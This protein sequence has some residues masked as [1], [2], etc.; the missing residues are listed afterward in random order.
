[1]KK[2]KLFLLLVPCLFLFV[3]C[4]ILNQP[5]IQRG[6]EES[7]SDFTYVYVVPTGDKTGNAGV[8]YSL[9]YGIYASSPDKSVNPGDLIAGYLMKRGY[10]RLFALD[11]QLKES[12][13]IVSYGEVG[14]RPV[15]LAAYTTAVT[16]QMV[17]GK[18]NRM[19]C[20]VTAE[21]IGDTEADDIRQ[22]ISRALEAVW[23]Q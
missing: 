20:S 19:V 22:A 16:I 12:T 17:S 2:L 5:V 11:S 15:G 18:T 9:G 14:T 4:Y 7:L 23:G 6:S 8:V 21:G 3:G 1:M 10:V 13:L